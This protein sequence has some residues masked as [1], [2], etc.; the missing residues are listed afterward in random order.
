M[1]FKARLLDRFGQTQEGILCEKFLALKQE[2]TVREYLC[3]FELLAA[4]LEG[5]PEQVQES[6]FINGL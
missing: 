4:M 2:G 5:M 6:T 3:L 1:E